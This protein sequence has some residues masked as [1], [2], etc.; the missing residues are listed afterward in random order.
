MQARY[1]RQ[2]LLSE[3]GAEGQIRLADASVLVV[4]AGGLGSAV[5]Q[6]L[7]AAGVGRIGILDGDLVS[8]SNLNRQILYGSQDIGKKKAIC[9]MEKLAQKGVDTKITPMSEML[10]AGNAIKIISG[11]DGVV[12]CVDSLEARII[13]NRAC[14]KIGIPFTDGAV[15]KFYGTVFTVIPGE[16]PCYECLHGLSVQGD[17]AVPVLGAMA[18]WIGCAE[19]LAVIRL[20]LEKDGP[21]VG[22]VL[23]YDGLKMSV[24]RVPAVREAG[25]FCCG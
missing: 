23:F 10:T 24:E 5:L 12:L 15:N 1:E 21:S 7:T 14:V 25:C 9:S 16:T 6:Y 13:A 4:G 17:E 20:L 8:A 2:V 11:Y 19:A 3:I 18:G 22:A